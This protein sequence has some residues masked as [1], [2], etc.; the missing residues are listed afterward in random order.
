[1]LLA[2][3]LVNSENDG[4]AIFCAYSYL[5]DEANIS[6]CLVIGNHYIFRWDHTLQPIISKGRIGITWQ[7]S[8]SGYQSVDEHGSLLSFNQRKFSQSKD[9][10][11]VDQIHLSNILLYAIQQCLTTAP[12]LLTIT[13]RRL[14]TVHS[15]ILGQRPVCRQAITMIITKY[16]KYV[17]SIWKGFNGPCHFNDINAGSC[18]SCYQNNLTHKRLASKWFIECNVCFSLLLFQIE[19][20]RLIAVLV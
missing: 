1:M 19:W 10:D 5:L 9:N 8:N 7:S 13:L 11:S 6:R 12:M 3:F 16:V 14:C 20:W 15:C 4:P 17:G 18:S 2:N